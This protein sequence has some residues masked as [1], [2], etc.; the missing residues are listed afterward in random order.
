[1]SARNLAEALL[2]FA[3]MIV[4]FRLT[5]IF[6]SSSFKR[7]LHPVGEP[8]QVMGGVT[9]HVFDDHN[10]AEVMA[11]RIFL[12]HADAAVQLDRVLRNKAACL[13]D[14]DFGHRDIVRPLRWIRL[15]DQHCGPPA[16]PAVLSP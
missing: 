16:P 2:S 8:R 9:E 15:V 14:P 6:L 13:T 5:L 4:W 11:D 1:M 7:L 3:G 12:G 10:T